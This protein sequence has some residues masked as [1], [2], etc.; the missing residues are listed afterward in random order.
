MEIMI[1]TNISILFSG[2][3]KN[4]LYFLSAISS[5]IVEITGKNIAE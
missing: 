2:I 1:P 4:I 5:N 3:S